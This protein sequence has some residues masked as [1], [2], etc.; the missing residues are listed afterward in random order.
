MQG[1]PFAVD[2]LW[3]HPCWQWR[4]GELYQREIQGLVYWCWSFEGIHSISWVRE[5][6]L[7]CAQNTA[8]VAWE[9]GQ[10]VWPASGAWHYGRSTR[11]AFRIDLTLVVVLKGD[12]DVRVYMDM[13]CANEA[14]ILERH[15]ISM[16]RSFFTQFEWEY[17]VQQE[18]SQMGFPSDS[19]QLGQLTDHYFVTHWKLYRYK[20][21]MFDVTSAPE[22]YQQIVRDVL[23]GCPLVVNSVDDLVFHGK[24]VL[25]VQ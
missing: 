21:L 1:H 16:G 25:G 23:R 15:P 10:E 6:S 9:G 12:G 20:W 18:W 5:D 14:V 19:A 24:G 4:T 8:W 11:W 13:L 3:S 22:K 7:A 2:S 17:H